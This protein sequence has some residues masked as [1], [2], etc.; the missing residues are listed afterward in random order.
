[1]NGHA[2]G[3]WAYVA[4]LAWQWIWFAVLPE[5]AGK[6]SVGLAVVASVPLLLPLMGV[7]KG[8]SRAFIWAGYLMLA[9]LML[10]L[11]EWWAAPPQRWA[12]AVHVLLSAGFLYTVAI[13][14]RKKS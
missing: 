14:T 6:N 7:W 9:Y 4:L 1:M 12:A 3:R 13:V 11:V 5:P 10:G 2:L 8:S